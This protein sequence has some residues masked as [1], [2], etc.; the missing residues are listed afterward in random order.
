MI[1]LH[2]MSAHRCAMLELE[3]FHALAASLLLRMATWLPHLVSIAMQGSG[4]AQAVC[5]WLVDRMFAVSD[6]LIPSSPWETIKFMRCPLR[7]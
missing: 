6:S 5:S 3:A 2:P 1:C 4:E 7:N